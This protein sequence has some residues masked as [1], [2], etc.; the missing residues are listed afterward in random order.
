MPRIIQYLARGLQRA[1]SVI[2]IFKNVFHV[3]QVVILSED[4]V[5]SHP[6]KLFVNKALY[7][8]P[9][10]GVSETVL[11]Q[12]IVVIQPPHAENTVKDSGYRKSQ[13]YKGSTQE[14][15]VLT[16][17]RGGIRR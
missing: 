17:S 1:I 6:W 2:G 8:S 4:R 12:R 10:F 13:H 7:P 15:D 11:F 14:N 5:S 9:L 16:D 3:T